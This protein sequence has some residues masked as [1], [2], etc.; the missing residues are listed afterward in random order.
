[1]RTNRTNKRNTK[2][3][4]RKKNKFNI[5]KKI[6]YSKTCYKIKKPSKQKKIK[7]GMKII[8]IFFLII[9]NIIMIYYNSHNNKNNQKEDYGLSF[10]E[11]LKD[12]N[13]KKFVLFG[14]EE[15]PFCGFF[16]FYIV[17]LGCANKFLNE[18]YIPIIDLLYFTNI[19]NKGNKSIYNPW[20]LFFH[21]P[22]DYTLEEVKKYAKSIKYVKCTK[23]NYRPDEKTIYFNNDSII[24]WHNFA[25]KYTPVKKELMNEAVMIMKNLFGN[26]KNILGVK[27]RGTDYYSRP[28]GHSIPPK[29]E[30][31]IPDVKEMD[32]K[33][34]YDFIFFATEDESVKKKFI[35]EFGEKIKMVNPN[36]DINYIERIKDLN[37]QIKAYLD[38]VKNYILNVI[39]LS[40]CLDI[41]IC[42]CCGSAAVFVLTEGFRHSI[43]YNL[44]EYK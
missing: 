22:N 33:Y 8:L 37:E 30:Q 3:I 13:T 27:I 20:E 40:K 41:V 44:G 23:Y 29:V 10:E 31:I 11:K 42:R 26:T 1:M 7:C 14:R 38:Y 28:R 35:P 16:S 6:L 9:V 15:C 34:N 24:F 12:Y 5:K 25:K 2:K 4:K 18:G 36:L 21:Q 17:H 43:V 19:F 32:K 39:I